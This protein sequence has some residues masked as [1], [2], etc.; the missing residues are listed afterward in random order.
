MSLVIRENYD[1]PQIYGPATLLFA[2]FLLIVYC[3][4]VTEEGN[5]YTVIDFLSS[6][7]YS[8]YLIHFFIMCSI[9]RIIYSVMLRTTLP[10]RNNVAF[11][12]IMYVVFTVILW[13]AGYIF[14][15]YV[16]KPLKG[17]YDRIWSEV[18]ARLTR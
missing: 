13:I 4:C 8:C 18:E 14:N 2:L 16:L 10:E 11:C 5:K 7:S 6:N 17:L 15:K 9:M 3:I 12:M 1:S